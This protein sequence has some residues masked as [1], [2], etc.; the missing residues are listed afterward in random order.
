MYKS[1]VRNKSIFWRNY[2]SFILQTMN[3]RVQKFKIAYILFWI[4]KIK[5][6]ELQIFFVFYPF[7]IHTRSTKHILEIFFLKYTWILWFNNHWYLYE[8]KHFLSP[9]LLLKNPNLW[10]IPWYS[11]KIGMNLINFNNYLQW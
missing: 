1:R 6:Q 5:E 10:I 9:K 8:F 3:S 4:W 11:F 7:Y 2:H